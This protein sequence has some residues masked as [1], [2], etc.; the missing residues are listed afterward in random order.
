MRLRAFESGVKVVQSASHSDARVA[1]R[2]KELVV[3]KGHM[4][5]GEFATAARVSFSVAKQQLY[6]AEQCG[7]VCRDDSFE[8]LQFYPNLF[9][10][11]GQ[12]TR[13]TAAISN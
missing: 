8:G 1:E 4:T 9:A 2:V 7:A 5:A 3:G 13:E 6:A 12:G 10:E 11:L